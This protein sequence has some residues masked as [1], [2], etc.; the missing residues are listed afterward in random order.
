MRQLLEATCVPL[1]MAMRVDILRAMDKRLPK[2]VRT[3]KQM[4]LYVN[5]EER[6]ARLE[7]I[8]E[9]FP[10]ARSLSDAVFQALS[11]WG[12]YAQVGLEIDFQMAFLAAHMQAA[13]EVL[14]DLDEPKLRDGLY[15]A[16]LEAVIGEML[17]GT[18]LFS[19]LSLATGLTERDV[20]EIAEWGSA[21]RRA[22]F[23]GDLP[24]LHKRAR[25]ILNRIDHMATKK[26][27]KLSRQRA[28]GHASTMRQP[29]AEPTESPP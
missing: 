27:H 11:V 8:L 5:S 17:A 4:S 1:T 10:S 20:S 16:Y 25:A 23:E 14:A 18:T 3:R 28:A 13:R 2:N 12:D 7:Q 22:L 24:K 29:K 26:L 21:K 9:E 19:A 6:V 15:A